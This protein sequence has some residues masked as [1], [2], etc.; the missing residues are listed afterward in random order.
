[1]SSLFR[2]CPL[3]ISLVFGT[4]HLQRISVF[5]QPALHER[6]CP[7][8]LVV[9]VWQ[10]RDRKRPFVQASANRGVMAVEQLAHLLDAERAAEINHSPEGHQRASLLSLGFS[11][12][13]QDRTNARAKGMPAL[14]TRVVNNDNRNI[15]S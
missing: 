4:R 1:M 5:F 11:L 7:P 15:S 10:R 14:N 12:A 3:C 9:D 6:P 13:K 8:V 2:Y